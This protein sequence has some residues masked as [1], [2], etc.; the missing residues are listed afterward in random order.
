MLQV[1]QGI[2]RVLLRR[3]FLLPAL[4][5]QDFTVLLNPNDIGMAVENLH[6]GRVVSRRHLHNDMELGIAVRQLDG[7]EFLFQQLADLGP[8][9][10]GDAGEHLQFPLGIAADGTDEG[11]RFN[12][13]K[14]AGGRHH[15]ALDIFNDIAAAGG[16]HPLRESPQHLPRLGGGIGQGDGLCAAQCGNQ[17]F[18]QDA[19]KT[20]IHSLFHSKNSFI[21]LMI[22]AFRVM[23]TQQA[24]GLVRCA[25]FH[26]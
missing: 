23:R 4:A 7:A 1:Q 25:G 15:D 18:F 3:R 11:R 22:T 2:I 16:D 9:L 6:Q 13:P 14:S 21:C 5:E 26:P 17:F 19:N 20:V 24:A 10:V 8:V 12:A